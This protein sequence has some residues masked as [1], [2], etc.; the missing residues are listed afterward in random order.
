MSREG[1]GSHMG[2]QERDRWMTGKLKSCSGISMIYAL[3]LLFLCSVLGA[4]ILGFGQLQAVGGEPDYES[5]RRRLAAVSAVQVV[6]TQLMASCG[7]WDMSMLDA[8]G[9]GETEEDA[10]GELSELGRLFLEMLER[11]AKADGKESETLLLRFDV[12][13]EDAA[14]DWLPVGEADGKA[15]NGTSVIP[16]VPQVQLHLTIQRAL[17]MDLEMELLDEEKHIPELPVTLEGVAVCRKAS[18]FSKELRFTVGGCVS[19]DRETNI[20]EVML[21]APVVRAPEEGEEDRS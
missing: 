8:E 17:D 1:E 5:E 3:L 15:V 14:S 6:N 18:D 19:Y 2:K 10:G 7:E 13:T 9:N 21:E 12:E 16:E 4:L 20:L 11:F